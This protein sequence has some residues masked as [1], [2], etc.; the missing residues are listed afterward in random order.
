MGTPR[1]AC[2]ETNPTLTRPP[3]TWFSMIRPSLSQGVFT[4]NG[5]VGVDVRCA[6]DPLLRPE[7]SVKLY[8]TVIALAM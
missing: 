8:E 5:V 4:I 3:L 1:L 7:G 2:P 6:G